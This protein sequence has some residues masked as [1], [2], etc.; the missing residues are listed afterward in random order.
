MVRKGKIR[1]KEKEKKVA[2]EVKGLKEAKEEKQTKA[3][4]M[5]VVTMEMMR[6]E[7]QRR[8]KDT[9]YVRGPFGLCISDGYVG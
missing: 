8:V 9:V 2:K 3:V 6:V 5:T 4:E 1:V 7:N